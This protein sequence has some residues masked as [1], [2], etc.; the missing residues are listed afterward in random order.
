VL[1]ELA[2]KYRHASSK[3]LSNTTH[4]EPPYQ[5]AYASGPVDLKLYVKDKVTPEQFREIEQIEEEER[6]MEMTYG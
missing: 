4:E 3:Q 2:K 6:A 1:E 5:A